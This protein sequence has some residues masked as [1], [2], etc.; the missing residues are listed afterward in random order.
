[1]KRYVFAVV[2]LFASTSLFA[3]GLSPAWVNRYE[4]AGDNSDVFN[5]IVPD[6]SG[7]FIAVG[8]TVRSGNYKD[9]LAVKLSSSLD[10]IWTRTKNGKGGGD[11]E[12]ISAVVDGSGNVYVGGYID[13][14]NT[15]D[16]FYLIKYD[17]S[18]N[19]IWDTAY[20][21]SSTGFLDD[22]PV[23]MAL[24]PTGN[25]I[26]A[27]WTE[28]G[29]WT[30][31]TL[32][33]LIVSFNPSGGV[34][35]AKKYG[36][37]TNQR[38]EASAMAV[39]ASGN[40]YV[41]G[42]SSNGIDDDWVTMKL[43]AAGTDLWSPVKIYD[44][45]NG[46][47][48]ATGIALTS[49]GS[50]VVTGRS[51]GANDDDF[52]TVWYSST[53]SPL[54]TRTWA[55]TAGHDRP[56]AI[57][58]DASDNVYITGQSDRD[59]STATNYDFSTVKYNSSAIQQWQRYW[60]GAALND[61]VPAAITTDT[62]GNI[63]VAGYSDANATTA[64][65]N[66]W[67]IVYYD[68]AGNSPWQK[69]ING[70]RNT[71]DAA[72]SIATDASGNVYIAGAINN[73]T[74]QRDAGAIKYD[75][76]GNL[77]FSK[78]YNGEGDFNDNG[79]AMVQD[80]S[81]NTYA[82]GYTY[83][84]TNNRDIFITKV[85]AT[86]NTV[87]SKT[88]Q[89]L[90]GDD[91]E[92]TGLA[93]DANGYIYACGYTKV[94]GE[95]SDYITIKYTLSLDTVWTRTYNYTTNQSDKAESIVVDAGGDVYVTGRSDA[96]ANDTIDNRDIVTIKYNSVGTQIWLQRYNGAA[97]LSDEPAKLI[98]NNGNVIVAGISANATD[99]DI[100]VL[101]YAQ[102]SGAA[103]AGFPV[104]F[105]SATG[106]N[107]NVNSLI[108]DASGN[109]YAAG[110]VDQALPDQDYVVLKYNSTGGAPAWVRYYSGT[111]GQQDHAAALAMDGQGNIIV[112]GKSDVDNNPLATNY[113]YLTIK[114]DAAGNTL[115]SAL[116]DY[117][118][119]AGEDDEPADV[120][121]DANNNIYVTGQSQEGTITIKNKDIMTRI[122]LPDGTSAMYAD[123]DGGVGADGG[124]DILQTGH[125]FFVTGYSEGAFNAQ[126]D[127]VVLKYDASV[128]IEEAALQSN[129]S[130]LYPNPFS[131]SANIILS[132]KIS[133]SKNLTLEVYDVLGNEVQTQANVHAPVV[134]LNR[135]QLAPGVYQ[136]KIVDGVT[137]AANGKFVVN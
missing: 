46:N 121:T 33:M 18:G 113:D 45:G 78:P 112:A 120:V 28:Q 84:E 136:Y 119:N 27:G 19:T 96:D 133:A 77:L 126:K 1:M 128:G 129:S 29:T 123:Y 24:A 26:L 137:T 53:G 66:D 115:W 87:V 7:N 63:I 98:L 54:F 42:R 38:D 3:Q 88:F 41:T 79:V 40:I 86:G 135:Q 52:L 22:H 110:Y 75:N 31:S 6:G 21:S 58:I 2:L 23:A 61:D 130:Y 125:S 118:G 94:S 82:A 122:Y 80:A 103:V 105:N 107:D 49:T 83:N 117:N 35:F 12:A 20:Y 132:G 99:E 43:S 73:N 81:G 5:K 106:K 124:N 116:P 51:R 13:N 134:H 17:N 70:S 9:F 48:R 108:A 56:I 59:A 60:S 67:A 15:G 76:G 68:A 100:V 85:D 109:I 34:V 93:Y 10:T 55:G 89:G 131:T 36:R 62:S 69:T 114:Y 127:I 25:V 65:S 50:V 90:K 16:D 39:D 44:G 64:I 14:G 30:A 4:G 102:S 101:E 74:S 37:F 72:N 104:V 92:L 47:D 95:K 57:A 97:N 111:S 8:F 91:D 32:D 11:D 71:D